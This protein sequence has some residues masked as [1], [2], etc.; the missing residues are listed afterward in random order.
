[1]NQAAFSPSGD[2]VAY[3]SEKDNSIDVVEV[4][5]GKRIHLPLA[6]KFSSNGPSLAW[7]PEETK[8]FVRG[9]NESLRLVV[10]IP[11]DGDVVAG[12]VSDAT[13]NKWQRS[14]VAYAELTEEAK[15]TDRV[16]ARKVTT[17][18]RQRRLIP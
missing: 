12:D 4:L 7:S 1:M 17:L 11:P 5:T 9:F 18:L 6:P 13:R 2:R 8:F 14:W 16:W 10:T 3:A 15:E